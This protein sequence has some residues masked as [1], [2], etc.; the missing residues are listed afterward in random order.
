MLWFYSLV[1]TLIYNRLHAYITLEGKQKAFALYTIQ[2]LK[3][4]L[5]NFYAHGTK[6]DTTDENFQVLVVV[7][8]VL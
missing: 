3:Y 1:G 5:I 7:S 6:I 4:I 8:S 2:Y